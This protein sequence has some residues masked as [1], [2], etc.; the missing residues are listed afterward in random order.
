MANG[1]PASSAMPIGTMMGVQQGLATH[2]ITNMKPL[3]IFFHMA[4]LLVGI[5]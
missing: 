1:V 4:L 5:G 3:R 2:A